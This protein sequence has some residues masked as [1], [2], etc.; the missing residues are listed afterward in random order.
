MLPFRREEDVMVQELPDETRVYD[1]KRN[2]AHCLN[3]SAA[4]VWRH[5]DGQTTVAEI[6]KILHEELSIPAE[7]QMVWQ[8]L[9]R[10][11]R[12]HLLSEPITPPVKLSRMSRRDWVRK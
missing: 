6:A 3:R 12:A 4:L 8:T 9:E 10:L 1:V 7:E 11:Q 5:C 2:K